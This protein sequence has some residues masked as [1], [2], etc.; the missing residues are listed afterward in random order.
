MIKF[1]LYGIVLFCIN[2]SVLFAG[3][4]AFGGSYI[5][6]IDNDGNV[7][8]KGDNRT[9]QLGLGQIDS[10]TQFTK[11]DLPRRITSVTTGL[12]CTTFLDEDH[13]VW[14]CGTDWGKSH[15]SIG[16]ENNNNFFPLKLESMTNIVEI[17]NNFKHTIFLDSSG[18]ISSFGQ[19][20]KGCLDL[21]GLEQI[22]TPKLVEG[23]DAKIIRMSTGYSQVILLDE[24]GQ[25]R[26]FGWNQDG[27]CGE[28]NKGL[29]R[30]TFTQVTAISTG[31]EHTIVLDSNGCIWGFGSNTFGQIGVEKNEHSNPTPR[32]IE[33][34][35]SIIFIQAGSYHNVAL[36]S[37]GKVFV[38]GL[39]SV[40][41]L[42]L[43][44]E[45]RDTH[46]P[47]KINLLNRAQEIFA[48][49]HSTMVIDESG[50]AWY[51]GKNQT[52]GVQEHVFLPEK[53]ELPFI[54]MQQTKRPPIKSARKVAADIT[55]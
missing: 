17:D 7:W 8:A 38:F 50:Q 4:V 34:L 16:S 45:M 27:Q 35:G 49:N 39:N 25:L 29:P 18:C 36:C 44:R 9:G 53:L 42:G 37:D 13:N 14:I 10:I 22:V 20:T 24:L 43:G 2:I 21:A 41:Q 54:V 32:Q 3:P 1:F 5:L 6:I 47:T 28:L 52:I 12:G 48:G 40:G 55:Q 11:L 33:N 51:F 26:G 30:S 23:I 46:I 31:Q 19:S 15:S